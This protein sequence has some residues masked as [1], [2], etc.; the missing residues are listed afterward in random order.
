MSELFSQNDLL[1]YGMQGNNRLSA[2]TL[3]KISKIT[4]TVYGQPILTFD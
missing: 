4:C 1:L 3:K 2:K